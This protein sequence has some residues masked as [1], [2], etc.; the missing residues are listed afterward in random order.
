[1][2]ARLAQFVVLV[3]VACKGQVTVAPEV[4]APQPQGKPKIACD[5]PE[6]DFGSVS[7][8]EQ[9]KHTFVVKNIGSAPLKI[10][11]ARSSCGCTVTVVTKDE[12]APGAE[13]QI[14]ATFN[15]AGRMGEQEKTITV[16]SND[17]DNPALKLKIKGKIEVIA[18]FEPSFVNLGRLQRG[19]VKEVSVKVIGRDIAQMKPGTPRTSDPRLG[20]ELTQ[21]DGLGLKVRFQAG[22]ETGPFSG[23]VTLAT[24]LA[25][26]QEITLSVN[27]DVSLD[28]Y[29]VPGALRFVSTDKAPL[30]LEVRSLSAK[31]FKVTGVKDPS[32]A[33][34][35]QVAQKSGQWTLEVSRVKDQPESGTLTI[36]TDRKD[37]PTLDVPW[38]VGAYRRS[39]VSPA[40]V[41]NKALEPA[42]GAL[43]RL[44]LPETAKG[45]PARRP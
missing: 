36:T 16:A 12:V 11:S 8:G 25:S 20:A 26:P 1:M 28:L 18:A 29:T 31:P 3:M 40:P 24:G 5:Q 9:V 10:E 32:G 27:A 37:Q 30:S 2:G 45:T 33:I 41:P 39:A 4:L 15:T 6:Y 14:E 22:Q 38:S 43:R 42:R 13:G 34:H 19:E 17:P 23:R 21:Q 44:R 7:Q 35:A